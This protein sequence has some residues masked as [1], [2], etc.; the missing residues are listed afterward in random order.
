MLPDNLQR[1]VRGRYYL[2]SRAERSWGEIHKK[3]KKTLTLTF[4]DKIKRGCA[5]KAHLTELKIELTADWLPPPTSVFM[6]THSES[7][8]LQLIHNS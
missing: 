2:L 8:C 7:L 1:E 6:A 5:N 3:K 4:C